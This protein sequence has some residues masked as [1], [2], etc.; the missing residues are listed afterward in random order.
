[1]LFFHKPQKVITDDAKIHELLTRG[2]EDVFVKESLEKKLR[3]GK[4]LRVKLGIDP[5]SPDLHLG[6]SVVLRKLREFQD[7]G[8][9]AVLIIGD[10]TATV[11]DPTGKSTARPPLSQQQIKKN[12]QNYMAQ[13]GLILDIKKSEVLY[14]RRWLERLSFTRVFEL[15]GLISASQ[16]LERD[17]FSERM[18]KHQS[19]R[20]TELF[21]PLMQAYDSVEIRADVELGGNDQLFNNLTG[22]TLMER[23]G[24]SPQDVLTV[25]L[26]VGT[27]GAQKMSKSL[28]NYIALTSEPSDMF[29]KVMSIH[30]GLIGKYF[31]LTTKVPVL[32]I[33][34]IEEAMKKGTNP[35]DSKIR[36]AKEIVTL[37]YGEAAAK[38]AA[39]NFESAFAKGKPEEFTE[40][41][42]SG[43]EIAEALMEVK[44]IASKTELR[45]LLS[46]GAITN[47]DSNT[48]MGEEFLKTAPPG[49]YRIGKHRFVEIKH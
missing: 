5:T 40:V 22:R 4:A 15:S 33:Q 18:Q 17:D 44:I 20:L 9:Q 42:L 46:E 48:K 19:I 1:M 41:R 3:L 35:R 34:K 24:M 13:A 47:L 37:Y 21:Y 23:L 7:L 6:H 28:G 14:N 10:F 8:H 25:S 32:E 30:D 29:G 49:K 43:K 12:M 38:K 31:L 16:I 2:V 27:D 39:E 45:R 36:L 11:G 26:L